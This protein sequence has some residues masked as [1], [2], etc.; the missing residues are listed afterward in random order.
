[1]IQVGLA[2][3]IEMYENKFYRDVSSID[4]R[5]L[6]EVQRDNQTGKS[7]KPSNTHK[8]QISKIKKKLVTSYVLHSAGRRVQP[9]G[10]FLA[11]ST[12][13]NKGVGNYD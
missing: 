10:T 6:V 3:L 1:V 9:C 12:T 7:D 13:H 11:H 4:K 8:N 5:D 2:I